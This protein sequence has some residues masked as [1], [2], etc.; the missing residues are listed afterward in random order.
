MDELAEVAIQ[1][2]IAALAGNLETSLQRTVE[3]LGSF[4]EDPERD[5]EEFA[6]AEVMFDD[7]LRAR[8]AKN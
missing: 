1:Q 8:R 2:E 6:R 5:A 3:L 7:P 4:Q